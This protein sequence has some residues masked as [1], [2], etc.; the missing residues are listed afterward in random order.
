MTLVDEYKRI[1]E[2]HRQAIIARVSRVC[3][4]GS[5]GRVFPKAENKD[6]KSANDIIKETLNT[7]DVDYLPKIKT[8]EEFKEWFE[9]KLGIVT[10]AIP[11]KNSKGKNISDDT[12]RWGYGTKILCLFLRDMVD[13]CRYFTEDEVKEVRKLLYVPIDSIIIDK[14]VECGETLPFN[15]IEEIDSEDKFYSIQ[16]KLIQAAQIIDVPRIWFDD[17]W[18]DRQ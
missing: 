4:S 1:K 14:L 9:K 3:F 12:R 8:Q 10:N 11:K 7:I 13:H 6:E 17:N 16:D 18:G 2:K 5:T 15:N